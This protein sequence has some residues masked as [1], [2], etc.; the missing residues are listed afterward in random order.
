MATKKVRIYKSQDGKGAYI[1]NTAKFLSKALPKAKYGRSKNY[2]LSDVM[3]TILDELSLESTDDDVVD[4][5]Q[6]QYGMSYN[7]AMDAMDTY[8]DALEVQKTKDEEIV[9]LIPE[10]DDSFGKRYDYNLNE[11]WASEGDDGNWEDEEVDD[12]EDT[13]NELKKGGSISRSKFVKKVVKGLK[14]ANEGLEQTNSNTG[15]ILDTPVDG[16]E[17]FM[18][19]FKRGVKDLGN[20]FYAKKIYDQTKSYMPPMNQNMPMAQDGMEMQDTENPMHHLQAYEN[21]TS[22]IFQKPMNQVHGAGYEIPQ[23]RKGREQR[24]MNRDW[25]KMFGNIA[26]GNISLPGLPSYIGTI[27]PQIIQAQPGTNQGVAGPL[28]DVQFKKGPWWKGTREWSIKGMPVQPMMGRSMGVMPGYGYMPSNYGYGS[29]WSRSYSYP[30]KVIS[31]VAS[32]VNAAADPG[33]NADAAKLKNNPIASAPKVSYGPGYEGYNADANGNGIP[34]FL[35]TNELPLTMAPTTTA[36]TAPTTTTAP[37]VKNQMVPDYNRYRQIE[38]TYGDIRNEGSFFPT[39]EYYDEF[40]ST[41]PTD[42]EIDREMMEN[43]QKYINYQNVRSNPMMLGASYEN[44]GFVDSNNPDLYKFI[45]GGDEPEDISN[46][47]YYDDN[48]IDTKNVEDPYFR[49]GG[50]YEA[51]GGWQVTDPNNKIKSQAPNQYQSPAYKQYNPNATAQS[52]YDSFMELQRRG[53]AEGKYNPSKSY[54]ISNTSGRTIDMRNSGYQGGYRVGDQVIYNQGRDN[55]GGG[56]FGGYMMNRPSTLKQFVNMFNPIQKDGVWLS[57]TGPARTMSGQPYN[58]RV[59]QM[60]TAGYTDAAGNVVKPRAGYVQDYEV[61]KGPWYT[62]GKTT[63]KVTNRWSDPNANN[64]LGPVDPN[65]KPVQPSATNQPATAQQPAQQNTERKPAGMT[66]TKAEGNQIKGVNEKGELVSQQLESSRRKFKDRNAEKQ[67]GGDTEYY[68]DLYEFQGL[69]NSQV[70]FSGTGPFDPNANNTG[71]IGQGKVGPC[72]EDEVVD[73]NSPC[74]DP[75]Y[76][77]GDFTTEYKANQARTFK[78]K[79]LSNAFKAAGAGIRNISGIANNLNADSNL[80]ANTTGDNRTSTNYLDYSGGYSGQTQ[81]IMSKTQGAGATGFNS[82]VGN[83]AFVKKGGQ[84]EY[85]EGG[86]YDLSQEEIGKI[87]AAGGQIKFIK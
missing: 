53:L 52:N 51:A 59:N 48:D 54:D 34:D 21:T 22:G 35:E 78:P 14:K 42:E 33:K 44:G 28:M 46:V 70:G 60:A 47:V 31:Q 19:D 68:P 36:P 8:K 83:A 15:N 82:V 79:K 55:Y 41:N 65:A 64:Y 39:P 25:N 69:D 10:T 24:Q 50:L 3:N 9:D 2:S 16:R 61:Q 72:N 43:Q 73:P 40:M 29:S 4:T 74:Y 58:P 37:T 38:D 63:M 71:G 56:Y 81:R 18:N 1:N 49:N 11:K 80:A 75:S 66:V 13:G 5:L 26:A 32:A 7:D 67:Y 45:Y 86:V 20:E 85:K 87:L 6:Q 27:S 57:Q 12:L 77:P 62:G 30:G 76:K 84:I 17:S 23:A